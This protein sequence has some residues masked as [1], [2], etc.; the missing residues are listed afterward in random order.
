MGND[1]ALEI[2]SIDTI[3]LKMYNGNVHTIHKVRHVKSLKKNLLFLRQLDD[4]CYKTHIEIGIMKII[5]GALVL[6]K[7]KKVVAN[8]YKLLG[9]T[10]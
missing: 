10:H 3:K 2:A 8:M 6:M 7:V 5:E 4:G 9:E 1:H